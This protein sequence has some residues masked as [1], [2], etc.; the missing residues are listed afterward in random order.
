MLDKIPEAKID[1]GHLDRDIAKSDIN[2][3]YES[4]NRFVVHITDKTERDK[5]V[6][7]ILKRD[8]LTWKLAGIDISKV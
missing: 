8:G 2:M 3:G 1:L 7:L 4:L 6:S 5:D